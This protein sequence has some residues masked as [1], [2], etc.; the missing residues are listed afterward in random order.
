MNFGMA[1]WV[2]CWYHD[3]GVNKYSV[4]IMTHQTLSLEKYWKLFSA[5]LNTFDCLL[6]NMIFTCLIVTGIE[7]STQ[8]VTLREVLVFLTK[9]RLYIFWQF[10]FKF[11]YSDDEY[12]YLCGNTTTRV[13]KS[14]KKNWPRGVPVAIIQPQLENNQRLCKQA[15][16]NLWD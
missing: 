4:V 8:L 12:C 16:I 9:Y 5:T 10:F 15:L 13:L 2:V 14:L 3:F 6:N 7:I 11:T 1:N